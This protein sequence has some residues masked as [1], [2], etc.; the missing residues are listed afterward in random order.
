[1]KRED[2]TLNKCN[3]FYD[4]WIEGVGVLPSVLVS[5]SL[6]FKLLIF[7]LAILEEKGS[8]SSSPLPLVSQSGSWSAKV[9]VGQPK[10]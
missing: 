1:M 7:W 4:E 2:R 5:H 3:Q 9:V 10:W 6:S 8:P